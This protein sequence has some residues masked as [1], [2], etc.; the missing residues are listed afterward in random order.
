MPVDIAAE[1]VA[2]TPLS[3]DYNVLSLAGPQIAALV[4]PGQFL[5]IKARPGVDPLLRR[6]F[7]VFELH[8]DASGAA[9]GFSILNKRVGVSTA[10]L[11]DARVGQTVMVLG[12][13]GRP[14]TLV[15]PDRDAWMVA[16]GVGLAPFAALAERL[17]AR[18]VP[19]T[20]FY[21]ARRAAELFH[22][23][24]FAA[25]G[26]RLVLATED[27]SRGE[28]GRIVAPLDRELAARPA[29]RKPMVYACGPEGM[30]AATAQVALRH[31][32]PC[33]VSVERLMGCGMG[34]C[35]SCVVPM[36]GADGRTTHV[37]SCL[38]GPVLEADRIAWD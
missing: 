14:F 28:P 13:L 37:R 23:E 22:L 3:A 1:V 24:F 5:M 33:E 30:L 11:Y 26:V 17:R 21:G 32:A 16:G 25:L 35:Y 36:M 2:N 6:P 19:T 31:D 20:L 15:G 18:G 12:P 34:G 27:G 29:G 8:R 10:L 4:D 7:S 9:T 38:A